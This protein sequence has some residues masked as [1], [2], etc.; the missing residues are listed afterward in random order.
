[1]QQGSEEWFQARIGK[2]T[3]SRVA[4]VLARTKTGF[5]ASRGNYMAELI[6]ERLTG[7]QAERYTNAAMQWGAETEPQARA[8]Y[9]I[10]SGV[11]VEECGL[12]IH[13]HI[14]DFGASPD[15]LIGEDGLV[16]IKC[17]NTATHIESLL[18][19]KVDGKYDIQMQAQMACTGRKW[20]DFVSFDPRMPVDMQLFV[21]RIHRDDVFIATMESE[22]VAFLA[23]MKSKI[24]ALNTQYAS[25]AA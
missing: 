12:F 5:G 13:S 19:R 6:C 11:T 9:E 15:G 7:M 1:M 17:P 4:D 14:A 22:I 21:T 10:V 8:S 3:G 2:V 23:E 16:E 18:S 25:K 24:E 20:C